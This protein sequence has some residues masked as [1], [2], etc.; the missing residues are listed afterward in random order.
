MHPFFISGLFISGLFTCR[1]FTSGSVVP[2][3]FILELVIPVTPFPAYT[4]ISDHYRLA[5]PYTPAP[6]SPSQARFSFR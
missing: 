4:V 1:L 3:P 6:Q 2:E 5:H